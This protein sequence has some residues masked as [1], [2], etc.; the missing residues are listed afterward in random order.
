MRI[1]T[2]LG[3]GHQTPFE[4]RALYTFDEKLS[5]LFKNKK[6]HYT[7]MLPLLIDNFDSPIIP[8]YTQEAKNTQLHVLKDEFGENLEALF[9][10]EYMIEDEKDFYAI[11]S[12]FNSI[13]SQD[14]E[15]IIDLT[16]GFR[17]IPILAT[18]SL[19]SHN[20]KDTSNIKH[21]F[22]AKEIEARKKY[23]IIDLKE[24]LELANIAYVLETFIDNY[25]VSSKI[26]FYNE[27]YQ[28]LSDELRIFS[29]HILANSYKH[30]FETPSLDDVAKRIN[31]ILQNKEIETFKN[32]LS[33]ILKHIELLKA[34][35]KE[36]EFKRFF[37]LS[38][39]LNE[40]GYLL[41]AITL[42]F[43]AIGFYCVDR[44]KTFDIS[45]KKHIEA[46]ELY[47]SVG[48]NGFD[49][50]TLTHKSRIIIKNFDNIAGD[51][52]FNP[53]TVDMTKKQRDNMSKKPRN[54]IDALHR[55]LSNS[56]QNIP[57]INL[58]KQ[59]V[60]DTESLRNN[61]AHGNS[62]NKIKN[63]QSNLSCLLKKYEIFCI[64]EDILNKGKK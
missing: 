48:K 37:E 64:K 38:R 22:F 62:S 19:I 6:H 44:F 58:F 14:E 31:K 27:L 46:Y 43:E 33:D 5:S 47:M 2:I 57:S 60:I 13:L 51:Y 12:L 49:M 59:F 42:L 1:I 53:Q 11:L 9:K 41:N 30:L 32:S 18:I 50:Y 54:E 55:I 35:K 28:E 16:H 10:A 45:L 40:R 15:T 26:S 39:L 61:L 25:T 3:I 56:L 21:I 52:L 4:N 20:I 23:E 7:N 34:L 63:A 29:N 17:H 36:P 8:I 24:Y